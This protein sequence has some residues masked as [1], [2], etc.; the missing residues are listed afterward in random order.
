MSSRIHAYLRNNV[1]GLVAIFIALGAGAYA[2]GLPKNSV[3]SKQIKDGQVKANDLAVDSVTTEK[4]V[5]NSLDGGAIAEASLDSAVLQ[6]RVS[7]ACPAN[8]AVRAVGQNGNVT[9]EASISGPPT[10]AAAGDLAGSY[11][12]PTLRAA[13]GLHYI[14]A[15]GEPGFQN[16]WGN[17]GSHFAKAAFYKDRAGVVHLRGL[18][19]G[20]T[21]GVSNSTIFSLPSAYAPCGAGSLDPNISF[22][23]F[24]TISNNAIGRISVYDGTGEAV[25]TAEVGSSWISLDGISWRADGC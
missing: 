6:S 25:V 8:E 15:A 1:L 24:G 12:D 7:G 14:G 17:F 22:L 16:S 11:P 9:C 20:G 2:A 19:N 3:K 21:F 5:D 13:E 18:V 23:A 4:V 10:G